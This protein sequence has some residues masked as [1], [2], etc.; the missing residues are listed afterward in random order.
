A[1]ELGDA[2]VDLLADLETF[3]TLLLT[4]APARRG[5]GERGELA[6]GE[7]HIQAGFL[8]LG[9]LAGDDRSLLEIAGIGERIALQLLH[10]KRD[11]LLLHVDVEHLGADLVALLDLVDHLLAR[12]LPIQVGEM[13]HA[14]DVAV[15]SEEEAGLRLVLCLAFDRATGPI[16]LDK[17]LPRI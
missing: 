16:F 15:E 9:D 14:V 3:G 6:A 11:A 7:L 8:D 4:I 5:L 1:V 17:D 2:G 10:A 12:S 13:D